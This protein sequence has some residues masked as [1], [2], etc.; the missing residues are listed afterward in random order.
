M[1]RTFIGCLQESHQD[2][3]VINVR[4]VKEQVKSA[5]L[6]SVEELGDFG[7]AEQLEMAK[8]FASMD[9]SEEDIEKETVSIFTSGI[10]KDLAKKVSANKSQ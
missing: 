7:G 3:S 1:L 2:V 10:I 5:R 8:Q 9:P 4:D 6:A